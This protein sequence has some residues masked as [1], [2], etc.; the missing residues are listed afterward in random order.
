V[1]PISLFRILP[2]A[3]RRISFTE[4]FTVRLTP[5]NRSTIGASVSGTLSR[6]INRHLWS[7]APQVTQRCPSRSAATRRQRRLRAPGLH[8]VHGLRTCLGATS[9]AYHYDEDAEGFIQFLE[10]DPKG[11]TELPPDGETA[12]T[13]TQ[14]HADTSSGRPVMYAI[15][16]NFLQVAKAGNYRW[17]PTRRSFPRQK[18]ARLDLSP[19]D[20]PVQSRRRPVELSQAVSYPYRPLPDVPVLMTSRA[21]FEGIN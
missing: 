18:A 17:E 19:R 5:V 4:Q 3:R 7:I 16:T 10:R 1:G 8:A 21:Q 12:R 9:G 11:L 14:I 2:S 6:Q 15:H 20:T 13:M